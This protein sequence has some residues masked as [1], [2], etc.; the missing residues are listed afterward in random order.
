[1]LAISHKA[2]SEVE[3]RHSTE[4]NEL[5]LKGETY[6]GF[7]PHGVCVRLAPSPFT[8]PQTC[9][10]VPCSLKCYRKLPFLSVSCSLPESCS[11]FELLTQ[12]KAMGKKYCRE[13]YL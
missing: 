9:C 4:L 8:S 13:R 12:G 6:P 10:A 1:M 5:K 7:P 3:V 11:S 2:R